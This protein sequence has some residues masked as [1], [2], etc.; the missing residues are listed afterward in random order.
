MYV[1][2]DGKRVSCRKGILLGELAASRDGGKKRILLSKVNGEL[3]ELCKEVPADACISFLTIR[4]LPGFE[5]YRRSASMLFMKSALDV[6]GRTVRIILHFSIGEGF[7]YTLEGVPS[8]DALA[9]KIEERM[10]AIA[11]ADLP[12]VKRNYKTKAARAILAGEGMT[13][14][15]RL[16]RFRTASRTNLYE[17]DGYYDYYYGF[18]V[19]SAGY[20]SRFRLLSEHGGFVLLFPGREDPDTVQP[21]RQYEK[22][23]RA[24]IDGEE[25]A[26]KLCIENI[27]EL[28][29]RV[30]EGS[31]SDPIL[32]SEAMHE[33][34]IAEIAK[35]V[36]G[37]GNVK[38]VLIAGPSSS[39]KT[40]F[41]QRLCIQLAT[42]GMRPHYLG[43]DNYF[44]SR[45][46]TPLDEH[47]RKDFESL[48]AID[49]KQFGEDMSALLR[50]EEIRV[51]SFN[52]AAGVREYHGE[53][54]SLPEGDVLVIEGIHCLN[55]DLSYM[56]PEESKFRIYLS[57]LAPINIDDHNR[58]PTT[59]GRLLRR[60]ARDNRTRG[61]SAANTIDM[62]ESVR[63]GE[64]KNIFP[65]QERA[66]VFFNSA[67]PYE[68]AVLKPY[69]Q[70][71]LFQIRDD[72]P[73]Y[74][75]AKRLLK[76]LD[77]VISIPADRVPANSI[78]REFIGGGIFKL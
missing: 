69:V 55:D 54:L 18:M 27:G 4:D 66:D 6:L 43:V 52:F 22:L 41:S 10:H 2:I 49:V 39:G 14:R 40:T 65:Y 9:E 61:L 17:L 20:V 34:K 70:P 30:C 45:E 44:L 5:T 50:G 67:L 29:E 71:L 32:Q 57:A 63:S 74:E 75:E 37:R 58:M 26:E 19:P 56:L 38:F 15:E 77:Y 16:L 62:W 1:T 68:L 46:D 12:I 60:M 31:M 35:T 53:T 24:Q 47:G 3:R 59:D 36:S 7:F 51:P 8:D 28:N 21:F 13:D 64:E 76:F 48:R 23:F 25:W 33:A 73:E 11:E 42:H 78:I 72:M